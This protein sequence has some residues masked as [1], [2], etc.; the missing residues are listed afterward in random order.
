M[1]RS[2]HGC[3]WSVSRTVLCSA[4]VTRRPEQRSLRH[5]GRAA[6]FF[7]TLAF[8]CDSKRAR[9][10]HN[11]VFFSLYYTVL[12]FTAARVWLWL[13]DRNRVVVLPMGVASLSHHALSSS[14]VVTASPGLTVVQ[15]LPLFVMTKGTSDKHPPG[16]ARTQS[17]GQQ[18]PGVRGADFAGR[19]MQARAR[20]KPDGF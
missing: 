4:T 17:R 19:H 14:G 1:D 18:D 13:A 20:A 6:A 8:N 9:R 12:I 7:R 15:H 16:C 3:G 2:V 10:S 11:A 5:S